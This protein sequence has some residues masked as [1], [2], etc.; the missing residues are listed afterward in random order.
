MLRVCRLCSI[1]CVLVSTGGSFFFFLIF[2]IFFYIIS[3]HLISHLSLAYH[4]RSR[5]IFSGTSVI[6]C[7]PL[8]RRSSIHRLHQL[9]ILGCQPLLEIEKFISITMIW[10]PYMTYSFRSLLIIFPS[11]L[12]AMRSLLKATALSPRLSKN[13]KWLL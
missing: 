7:L 2:K 6:S 3:L 4:R 12:L 1:S 9:K 13:L 10:W 11:F 5:P 8:Q